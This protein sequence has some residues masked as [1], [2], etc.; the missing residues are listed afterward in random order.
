MGD[1]FLRQQVRNFKKRRDLA[2]AELRTP[3]LFERTAVMTTTY[4]GH[5]VPREAFRNDELLYAAF[6]DDRCRVLLVRGNR[7]VGEVK[8]DGATMLAETLSNVNSCGILIV[9][10]T[11][12][13]PVSGVAQVRIVGNRQHDD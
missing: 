6:S 5:A 3:E 1:N 13:A 7:I 12:V 11:H 8:G 9:R 4:T 2:L 10:V